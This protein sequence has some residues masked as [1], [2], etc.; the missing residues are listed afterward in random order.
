MKD[1]IKNEVGNIRIKE[2]KQKKVNKKKKSTSDTPLLIKILVWFMLIA[3]T[4][5]SFGYIIYLFI[6]AISQ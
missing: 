4:L 3:M 6:T 1:N 2:P 5:S